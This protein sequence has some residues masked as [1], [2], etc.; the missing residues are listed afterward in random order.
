MIPSPEP[1]PIAVR[2]YAEPTGGIQ[3]PPR[4]DGTEPPPPSGWALVFDTETTADAAQQLRIGAYQVRQAGELREAG[5]FYDPLCLADAERSTLYGYASDHGF[6]VRTVEEFVEEVFFPYAYDLGGLCVGLNLP[7]DLARLAIHHAPARGS[8][9]GGFSFRLSED[10]R[11]PRVQVKHLT[12]RAALIQFAKPRGQDTPRG[13]RRRGLRVPAQRGHVADVRTLAGALLGGSWTLKALADHLRTAHRK[14]DADEH[15]GML[16]DEYLDYATNDVQVTWECFERLRDRYDGYGLTRTPLTR[17]YSEASLGKACLREMGVRPWREL[18]PDF[19]PELLGSILSTYYGGRAEV[20]LRRVA[21]RV[22]YCDFLSMYPTVCT[23]MDLWE[24]VTAKRVAW[25]D[26]TEQI[27]AFLDRLTVADL[28][29]PATW[30]DLRVLVQVMPDGDL[31]PVRADYDGDGG[32]TIGL[33]HLSGERPLW[34]TLA[35]CVASKLLTGK[36]PQVL[37]ALRFRPEGVQPGLRPIDVAGN[38]AYRVDPA[39]DD[40]YRRLI[41]LR[42]EVKVSQTAAEAAGDEGLAAALGAEQQALKITANATSY[43]IFVELNVAEHGK[44]QEVTCH[45]PD[46]APF[47]VWVRNVEEPGRY[48]Y[49]LLATLI[50]G[51]ARLMLALAERLATDEGIGW[52]FCDTDSMALARPDGMA[53]AEFLERAR[54][55]CDWFAPLNPYTVRGPLLKVEDANYRIED[56][57]PTN[58]LEPLFC[59]AISAKRYALFNIDGHGRPVLRKASAHGLGHLRLPYGDERAPRSIPTPVVPLPKLGVERWQHDVWY[60]VVVAALAG[61]PDRPRLD[62]LPGFKAPAVSRY[63]ATTPRLL[64][65]FDGHN[66]GRPYRERVRPFG[67]LLAF[68]PDPHAL[69]L[70][71]APGTATDPSGVAPNFPRPVAPYDPDP[72]A[73]ARACFDRLTGRPVPAGALK[74]YRQALAQYHLHPEAKF[75]H[76]D[77]LDAGVTDRRHV[78]V[79]AVEH[80]GKEANRWEEQLYLGEDPEAQ[81]VYGTTPEDRERLRGTLLRAGRRFGQRALAEVAGVSAREVGAILRGE[82]Q[83]TQATRMK[84]ARA[85]PRLEAAKRQRAEHERAV[86]QGVRARSRGL[87]VRRFAAMAGVHYPHLTEVLSGRRRPSRAMLAK[88]EAALVAQPLSSM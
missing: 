22:L 1:R 54:R 3:S 55:V 31:F 5:L 11:R 39:R 4:R 52:A 46:D 86:L 66:R 59:F 77:Y 69:S 67:F 74:T 24:F 35:D 84:L 30:E 44:L 83:P 27:R 73:A 33:N 7:F 62:D 13:M 34:F 41:D 71:A 19:P 80:I 12:G 76:A 64:R 65:W 38:P 50:T 32:Y 15:G 17:I 53:D 25:E 68:Q 56:G 61:L 78:V 75:H 40:F 10:D 42:T 82:R 81:I 20:R 87:S 63:A 45:G 88:L 49:P 6:A 9:R 70:S 79:E 58:E 48:F 14:Q 85:I 16:T 2:A 26:A 8:M 47:S 21:A 51:A 60:R 23:L 18:Q 72:A 29:D 43:G 57:K 37:Q 36:A 28:Q